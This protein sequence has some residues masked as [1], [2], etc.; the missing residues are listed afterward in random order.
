VTHSI[1]PLP[2]G[3]ATAA[4]TVVVVIDRDGWKFESDAHELRFQCLRASDRLD[5]RREFEA[6]V[7][8]AK[9]T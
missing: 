8:L 1:Y 5:L 6:Q 7:D 9:R 2:M 4:G 3:F